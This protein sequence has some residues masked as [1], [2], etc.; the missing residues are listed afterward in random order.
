M[1]ERE[2]QRIDEM[3]KNALGGKISKFQMDNARGNSYFWE[4]V[5]P[6]LNDEALIWISKEYLKNVSCDDSRPYRSYNEAVMLMI[7]PLL[8]KRLEELNG[9]QSKG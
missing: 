2:E 5:I 8:L 3:L 7:A 6:H 4:K 9:I 1:Y